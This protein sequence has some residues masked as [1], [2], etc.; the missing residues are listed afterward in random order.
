MLSK[1]LCWNQY[2]KFYI[3][4]T[5]AYMDAL[6]KILF[7]RKNIFFIIKFQEILIFTIKD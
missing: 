6:K 2:V 7:A 1:I 3:R 4:I 5:I